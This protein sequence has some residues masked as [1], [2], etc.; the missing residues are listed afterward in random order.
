[1]DNHEYQNQGE[2]TR[3][4]EIPARQTSPDL[5]ETVKHLQTDLQET[6]AKLAAL[7]AKQITPE[8]FEAA[9]SDHPVIADFRAFLDKYHRPV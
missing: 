8:Q 4:E 3:S 9:L 6:K 5:A 7:E 1:M 2:T